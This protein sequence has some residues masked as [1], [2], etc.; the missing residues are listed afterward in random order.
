MLLLALLFAGLHL[1]IVYRARHILNYIVLE[2][3][4]GAY[5]IKTKK[6]RF[7]YSPLSIHVSGIQVFPV[8]SSRSKS[9]YTITADSAFVDIPQLWPFITNKNFNLNKVHVMHPI[10]KVYDSDTATISKKPLN[11]VLT[12]MQQALVSSLSEFNV[13]ECI[14]DD[15]AIAYQHNLKGKR[16]FSID[17]IFFN[18]DNLHATR[19][20]ND[21]DTIVSFNADIKLFIDRPSIQL[22]DTSAD[23]YIQNLLID[24]RRNVFSVNR[25]N[26]HERNDNGSVDS[27]TLSNIHFRNFNWKRWLKEGVVEIDSLKAFDGNTFFDLSDKQLFTFGDKTRLVKPAHVYVPLIL[28]S[29]QINKI[30]YGLRAGSSSGPLAVQMNGDSLGIN[31]IRLVNDSIA[32]LQVG[33][34]AFKVTGFSNNYDNKGNESSFDKLIIDHNDLEL[35]NYRRALDSKTLASGSSISIPS[36]KV[37][38]FSLEDLLKYKLNA[39]KLILERP[40]LI[41]DIQQS[42][43]KQDADAA[44]AAITKSLRPSL[45]IKRLSIKDAAIILITK[46]AA[47]G[48]VTIDKLN[49]EID[50]RQLLASTSVMDILGSATALST[51]GFHVTGANVDL[52]VSRSALNSNKDGVYFES[53][54]GKLGVQVLLDLQGVSILDKSQRFDVT[55]LQQIRFDNVTIG[56]GTV[57]V[58][59]DNESHSNNDEVPAFSISQLHAGNF[60]FHVVKAGKDLFIHDIVLRGDQVEMDST[61]ASWGGISIH[62]GDATYVTPIG[63]FSAT[64][65][66]VSQPGTISISDLSVVPAQGSILQKALIP[67]LSVQANVMSTALHKLDV[68]KVIISKPAVLIN[69]EKKQPGKAT[70]F[71]LPDLTIAEL[72]IDQPAVN[73]TNKLTDGSNIISTDRGSMVLRN[74]SSDKLNNVITATAIHAN[75]VKPKFVIDEALYEPSEVSANAS[76]AKFDGNTAQLDAMIDSVAISNLSFKFPGDSSMIIGN[77]SAVLSGYKYSSADSLSIQQ[78]LTNSK[79][80][81]NA[82]TLSKQAKQHTLSFYHPYISSDPAI[83]S[84]DSLALT[85]LASRDSFWRSIPNEKDYNTL[86]VGYTKFYNWE[87]TG[88]KHSKVFTAKYLETDKVNL[89]TE[90]DKTHGPDTVSYRPL[91]AKSL[92]AIPYLFAIDTVHV[93]NGYVRHN[94]WPE[95]S[96]KEATLFFSDINGHLYNVKNTHYQM[97]DSLRFVLNSKLMGD[98]DL[99]MGFRQSYTDSLQSFRLRA[100]MGTMDLSAMNAFLSPVVSIK[101]DRGI[102]DSML[103]IAGANDYMAHGSMDLRYHNLRLLLLKKGENQYFMSS[104]VNWVLNGVVRSNDNSSSKSLFQERLRNKAIYNYWGRIAINGFL[105]N[106]GFKREK[107][108]TRQYN[109]AVKQR[110]MPGENHG[111]L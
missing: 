55:R 91:L 77:A 60:N 28:H 31:E 36:L 49:T 2:A 14:I 32:P 34:V 38:N 5:A 37:I 107:K 22:P 25:F 45:D 73:Y 26:L 103:L 110:E 48:K 63:S 66:N 40:S 53:I 72:V 10:V 33:S 29:V 46:R 96:K 65:I 80:H 51:S 100:R 39:D 11:M 16:P 30:A 56:G 18:I 75:F 24:T 86:K 76:A 74:V 8:D 84:F 102:M 97:D 98:G 90:K 109:K 47:S 85:P 27:I 20:N 43:K 54:K 52:D 70:A 23:V 59:G 15:A 19:Q 78:L 13:K 111:S 93:T 92:K 95:K 9:F 57:T 101:I 79:W 87:L 50:A 94:L 81:A 12:D 104:F 35:K 1:F 42:H 67:R 7:R 69:V 62:S 61:K 106:L 44:V 41:I 83:I 64:A 58:Y 17:H 105:T 68:D 82:G 3:S 21:H 88:E 71:R 4:D 108:Q 6:V 99:R 89:L